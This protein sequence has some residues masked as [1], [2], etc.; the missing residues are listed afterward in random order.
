MAIDLHPNA[1]EAFN[2]KADN[3]AKLINKVAVPNNEQPDPEIYAETVNPI[4][5]NEI[6][7]LTDVFNQDHAWYFKKG[8]ECLGF[9]D[10]TFNTFISLAQELYKIQEVSEKV[11]LSFIK[12]ALFLWCKN[13][14]CNA[15]HSK[16]IDVFL[17]SCDAAVKDHQIF[18]PTPYTIIE[19]PFILGHIQF[20]TLTQEMIFHWFEKA[21]NTGNPEAD[22]IMAENMKK[23]QRNYQGF[24]IGSFSCNA[25]KVRAEEKA[26]NYFSDSICIIRLLS[27]ANYHYKLT[28]NIY[29]FGHKMNLVKEFFIQECQTG[30]VTM[31]HER[32]DGPHFYKI[33]NFK[34][35]YIDQ[36]CLS[37]I[38]QL[39]TGQ[40]PNDYKRIYGMLCVF[41]QKTP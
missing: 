2:S 39:L 34:I 3:L 13:K 33:N 30:L 14:Y 8:D 15:E 35:D 23:V 4:K 36:G 6:R 9:I 10:D 41:T 37:K 18:I 26:Y 24:A 17:V 22:T 40:K 25:E 38:N 29:E 16:F 11:S 21:L 27:T 31:K 1:I 32:I 12:N 19:R 5:V 7:W 28:N 20:F